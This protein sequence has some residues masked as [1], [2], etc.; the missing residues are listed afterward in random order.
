MPPGTAVVTPSVLVIDRSADGARVSVSVA[1][2][3]AGSGR[4]PRAVTVAVLASVPVAAGAMCG[5]DGVG[6]RAADR[7]VTGVADVAAAAGGAAVPPPG[8]DAGPGDAGDGAGKVSATR[9]A[10]RVGRAGVGDHDGVGPDAARHRGGD[11]VGLG[12]GQVGLDVDARRRLGGLLSGF[13]SSVELAAWPCCSMSEPSG[14]AGST[15]TVM[16]MG[17]TWPGSR[18]PS[19]RIAAPWE[20]GPPIE[21][22]GRDGQG[23][24]RVSVRLTLWASDG[25]LLVTVMV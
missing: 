9:G 21:G 17:W 8:A 15:V 6:D 5:D 3:L 13:G 1:L 11:A 20:H 14:A 7:E 2:L 25:P 23:G 16:T 4:Q 10:G 24:S 22:V 18:L 19:T 12:D